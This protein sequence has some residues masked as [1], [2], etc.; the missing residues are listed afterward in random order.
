MAAVRS[1]DTTPELAVRRLLHRL[2]YRFRLHRGDLPGAPDI[3]LPAHSAVIF[4]HGCFW[5]Q[6]SCRHGRRPLPV[7]NG[8]YWE[9]KLARNVLRDRRVRRQLRE[10]G[11]RVQIVWECQTAPASRAALARKLVAFL[12]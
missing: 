4:V 11:W 1:R 8:D 10:L 5:H 3:V 9:R 6:H 12:R 7:N 2:G